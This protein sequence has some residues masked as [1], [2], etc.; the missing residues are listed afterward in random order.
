[1]AFEPRFRA[2]ILSG[3]GSSYI[4]NILHKEKPVP[5]RPLAQMLFGYTLRLYGL[6]QGD[7]ALSMLQWAMEPA[8]PPVCGAPSAHVLM[9]Q[10]VVDHYLLPPSVNASTLSLGLDLAGDELDRHLGYTPFRD[11]AAFSGR[12]MVPYPVQANAGGRAAAVQR[13]GD[14]IQDGHEIVFQTK[15]P[16]HQYRCFLQ[17]FAERGTPRIVAPKDVAGPCE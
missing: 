9:F 15:G 5:V 11:V 17:S 3:M 8:D 4:A 14:G 7:P 6:H 2:A 10:G 12:G 16:K 13:A 1:M